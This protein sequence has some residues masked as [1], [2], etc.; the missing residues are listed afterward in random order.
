MLRQPLR[1]PGGC[2]GHNPLPDLV[3]GDSGKP[4]DVSGI[5]PPDKR[6]GD[7]KHQSGKPVAVSELTIFQ[8]DAGSGNI[9]RRVSRAGG[10]PVKHPDLITGNHDI[11]RMKIKVTQPLTVRKAG[12]PVND[13]LFL[14]FRKLLGSFFPASLPE[15]PIRLCS[16]A[17]EG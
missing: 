10:Q 12:K 2:R 14:V 4:E 8:Q 1:Q 15:D 3:P 17:A 11:P 5:G 6:F 13:P 7:L 9:R 16:P